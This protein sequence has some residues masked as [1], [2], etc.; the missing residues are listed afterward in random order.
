MD[1]PHTYRWCA[2]ADPVNAVW[3][4]VPALLEDEVISSW[5]VRCALAHDCEPTTLTADVW[6]ESRIWCTDVDRELNSGQL[7]ALHNLSGLDVEMLQASTLMRLRRQMTESPR[8]PKGVASWFL[9]L[10]VRN[11]RRCGGLQYCPQ[12]FDDPAPHYLIQSRLAWHTACPIHNVGLLDRCANCHSPLCPQL[13]V[14]PEVDL[15][16]CHRCG[17]ELKRAAS[18]LAFESALSFQNATDGLFTGPPLLY[19][20]QGLPIV[21]WLFLA[22]WMLGV[23]RDGARA[24]GTRT[25]DFFRGLGVRFDGV[26]PPATGLRFEYLA[27]VERANLLA[28]VWKMIK[29]GPALLI[30]LARDGN[31]RPSLFSSQTTVLPASLRELGAVIHGR[32][33]R[34][35]P[36]TRSDKPRSP[37]NVLMRWH[38]LL[39][40]FQR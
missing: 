4:L 29:A 34:H 2:R 13:I 9:C 17:Y 6:P 15:S 28:N 38:R 12:C 16:R 22:K 30:S 21:E 3:P 27:P 1:A 8:F 5:L 11:R 37:K 10:G 40:K 23:L 31:V 25:D 39:R 14:P 7:M 33:Q 18:E 36:Q 19:G 32:C 26:L 20:D 35:A 24:Q